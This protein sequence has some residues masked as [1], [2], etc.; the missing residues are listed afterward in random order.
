[1]DSHI[2][3]PL[4]MDRL[5]NRSRS[6]SARRCQHIGWLWCS[7]SFI[8]PRTAHRYDVLATHMELAAVDLGECVDSFDRWFRCVFGCDYGNHIS[9]GG[10]SGSEGIHIKSKW[11]FSADVVASSCFS[12]NMEHLLRSNRSAHIDLGKPGLLAMFGS[13]TDSHL[14]IS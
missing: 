11:N 9:D 1:M 4:R 10:S 7:N 8:D 14:Y 2:D 13:H 3:C 12:S 5:G 6:R